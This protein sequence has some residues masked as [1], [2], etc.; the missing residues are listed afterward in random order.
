[1]LF[2]YLKIILME[3]IISQSP[4]KPINSQINAQIINVSRKKKVINGKE[5]EVEVKLTI[6]EIED[7][8]EPMEKE[9]EHPQEKELSKKEIFHKEVS[10][11][12]DTC[13]KCP[14]RTLVFIPI[15]F[16][17]VFL[18]FFDFIA[19][20]VVPIGMCLFYTISFICNSCK[21]V[22]SSYQV[23]EEIGFSGAFT[24]ENEIKLHINNEG[25]AFHLTEILCFSY[26]SA[27]IKR[28]FCA[29]FVLIN[30]II[31]PILHSWYKAKKCFLSSK[32]EE[33]YDERI[34]K[35]EE[36]STYKGYD[37]SEPKIEINN[38]Q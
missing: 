24:S 29:I 28:Y 7:N 32:V 25:G 23:E 10:E 30:H 2:I 4:R 37:K 3:D 26:M 31:V 34:K 15:C 5:R 6:L 33:L 20:L 11:S 8:N 17:Y 35:I 21:N 9:Y 16:G 27:C 1:M 18:G 38:F 36:E 14:L 12:E 19:Y 13:E 22:I